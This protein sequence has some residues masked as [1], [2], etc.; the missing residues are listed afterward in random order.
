DEHPVT[1]NPEVQLQISGPAA[2]CPGSS[3]TLDAG[4]GF[5]NYLWSSG[6]TT[7]FITVN[8]PG[9]W[10]VQV[11][12]GFGCTGVSPPH[13]VGHHAVP[14]PTVS[15]PS[16]FCPGGSV[17]LNAGTGYVQYVWNDGNTNP[18]RTVDTQGLYSVTVTD[19]NG[20]VG[21]SAPFFVDEYD[22]PAPVIQGPLT[23]CQGDGTTLFL[24]DSAQ[25]SSIAWRVGGAVVGTGGSRYFDQTTTNISVQV[26][27]VNGCSGVSG[28]VSVTELNQLAPTVSGPGAICAGASAILTADGGYSAYQWFR[29]GIALVGGNQQTLTVSTAG[30]YTVRVSDAFGCEGLS[31]PFAFVVNDLPNLTAVAEPICQGQTATLSAV[32]AQ[33]YVW[34]GG[35]LNNAPGASVNV[36]PVQT[37]QYTVT[38]TDANGC[39]NTATVTLTV[40]PLPAANIEGPTVFCTGQSTQLTARPDGMT[41]LWSNNQTAQTIVVVAG[42]DYAVTVTDEFGC[43]NTFGVT[44]SQLDSLQP[45]ITGPSSFCTGLSAQLCVQNPGNYTAFD[46]RLNGNAVGTGSCVTVSVPGTYVVRTTNAAGC[47]GSGTLELTENALPTVI[48]SA[49]LVC[50]G[51]TATLSAV[52]AQTYVWNGGGLTNVPGAS[53]EVSPTQTTQ[54][55]VTGTDANGCVNTATVTLTVHPLPNFTVSGPTTVCAGETG[56][57]TIA[58]PGGGTVRYCDNSTGNVFNYTQSTVCDFTVTSPAGCVS[59]G[60]LNLTVADTARPAI[61]GV[62]DYCAGSST[63]LSV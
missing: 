49:S 38:G 12:D 27:D 48:A 31:L 16:G 4:A 17:T 14:V 9:T 22:A 21:T 28:G 46:W 1:E 5:V 29:D 59:T 56:T 30:N 52:G 61:L 50:V 40:R 39:V 13:T 55:T 42:G 60:T 62:R 57:I 11:T 23:F 58:V 36:S 2:F 63:I 41:Y 8:Q 24:P 25:Y 37:T 44:V 19:A 51:E 33:T 34:N 3:A 45:V 6:E 35:G 10:T 47:T 15:G 7:R 26:V 20:C 32:G 18:T 43:A 53:V 54:Y